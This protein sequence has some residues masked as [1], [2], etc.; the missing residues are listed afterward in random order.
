M[1][2]WL[3]GFALAEQNVGL[4]MLR[5]L[6]GEAPAFA[7]LRPTSAL[8][9]RNGAATR[10]SP[11]SW[12]TIARAP[13]RR[14]SSSP[15]RACPKRRGTKRALRCSSCAT[16]SLPATFPGSIRASSKRRRRPQGLSLVRGLQN[17]LD[18]I[19]NNGGY[20][21]Q[22]DRSGFELGVNI[23]ATPGRVVM[24]NDAD[25]ADRLRSA[26][27]AGSR[28]CHCSAAR[29]GSTNTTSWTWPQDVRSSS[30]P[31]STGTRRS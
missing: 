2:T 14:C 6:S 3:T 25:G 31:C 18:D 11:A 22:V 16:P 28:R 10:S 23:A 8:P 20:P 5:R 12:K 26:D 19:A 29:R 4:N 15:R 30:G 27:A 1:S 17:F 21:R 13:T 9:T 24:R 7:I